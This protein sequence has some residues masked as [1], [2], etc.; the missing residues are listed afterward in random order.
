[1]NLIENEEADSGE[2][3]FDGDPHQEGN[4]KDGVVVNVSSIRVVWLGDFDE[5]NILEL[6]LTGK[7]PGH[8]PNKVRGRVDEMDPPY[9]EVPVGLFLDE[10]QRFY[11]GEG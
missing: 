11:F 7:S 5:D 10:D 8:T 4:D 9:M 1:M 2:V 6:P 3:E